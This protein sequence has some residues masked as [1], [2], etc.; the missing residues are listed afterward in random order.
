MPA[1]RD[2][3]RHEA[4]KLMR[5]DPKLDPK[6]AVETAEENTGLEVGKSPYKPKV[7]EP[8]NLD[9]NEQGENEIREPVRAV[10][11]EEEA[12]R[13]LGVEGTEG[14]TASLDAI[15]F[16]SAEARAEAEGLSPDVFVGVEPEGANGFTKS[17]VTR[18]KAQREGLTTGE[19][20]E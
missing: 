5:N 20:E 4:R 13:E 12:N 2:P 14:N 7:D 19:E 15:S 6:E 17:Q 9:L 16:A 3:I 18:L 1:K 8:T 10:N 11:I